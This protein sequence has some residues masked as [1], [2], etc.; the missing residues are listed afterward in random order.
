MPRNADP[1]IVLEPIRLFLMKLNLLVM[2][3]S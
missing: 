3:L 1:G 2:V